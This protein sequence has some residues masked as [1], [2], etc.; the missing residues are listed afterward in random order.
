MLSAYIT[1]HGND[2]HSCG[3]FCATTHVFRLNGHAFVKNN[4]LPATDPQLGCTSLVRSGVVPNEYGTWLYGRDG[5]CNGHPVPLWE[6]DVSSASV[7]GVNVLHYEGLWH[8]GKPNPGPPS[9]WQQAEPVIMLS[10]YI[11]MSVE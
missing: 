10:A 6:V 9:A 7:T 5:W 11:T 3:E 2:M 4:S 1:G 8:G